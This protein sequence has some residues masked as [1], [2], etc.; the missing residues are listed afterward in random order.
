MLTKYTQPLYRERL[1]HGKPG[2]SWNFTIISFSRPQ[3][4]RNL[5]VGHGKSCKMNDNY[6]SEDNET[7]KYLE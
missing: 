1:G 7:R 6:F 2:K 5:S 3:K 4:S